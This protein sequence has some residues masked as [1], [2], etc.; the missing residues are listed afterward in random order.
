[1]SIELQEETLLTLAQ[2][3]LR[4]PGAPHVSTLHRWRLRGVRGVKL[5]TVL[6]GGRRFTSEE[7]LRRFAD[8]LT[9][10]SESAT[11]SQNQEAEVLSKLDQFGI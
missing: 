10:V 11:C 5:E 1:M 8:R 4:T 9:R 2:A 7:A 3:A 6:I